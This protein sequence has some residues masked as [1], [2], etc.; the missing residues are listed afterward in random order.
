MVLRDDPAVCER[1]RSKTGTP[2]AGNI[3]RKAIKT[4]NNSYTDVDT[5]AM[6]NSD[7]PL[8]FQNPPILYIGGG[9]V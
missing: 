7:C 5:T 1:I 3:G 2:L 9:R 4:D 8:F 6:D